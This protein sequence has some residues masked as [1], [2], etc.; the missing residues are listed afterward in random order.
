MSQEEVY[1]VLK[2]KG[3]WMSTKQITRLLDVGISG[4][5]KS[6]NR[7]RMQGLVET[8]LSSSRCSYRIKQKQ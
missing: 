1:K 6:I 5:S 4:V 8:K 2:D 7:L 3:K